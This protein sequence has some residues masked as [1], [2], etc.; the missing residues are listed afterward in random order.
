M[1][2]LLKTLEGYQW[3]VDL[4]LL[5]VFVGLW[6]KEKRISSTL[7]GLTVIAI[8]GGIGVQYHHFLLAITDEQHK[9]IVR[10]AWYMGFAFIDFL[11]IV[12]LH[13]I[14][15]YT[16]TPYSFITKAFALGVLVRGMLQIIRYAER[17]YFNT[18]YLQAIY[19]SGVLAINVSLG[20]TAIVFTVIVLVSKYR[21]SQGQ[22]GVTWRV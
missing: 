11:V 6:F 18:D 15:L 7:I 2:E 16:K 19:K 5:C 3:L 9:D 4:L 8:S 17:F 20:I 13:K 14:H 10:F 1:T 12:S 22:R 21:E